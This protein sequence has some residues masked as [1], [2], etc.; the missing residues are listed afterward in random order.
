MPGAVAVQVASSQLKCSRA[1]ATGRTAGR[2]PGTGKGKG[3]GTSSSSV[4]DL[5]A[6]SAVSNQFQSKKEILI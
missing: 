4:T 1:T 2:G 6:G 5:C 3:I